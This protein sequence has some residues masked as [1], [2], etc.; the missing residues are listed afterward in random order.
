MHIVQ[1]HNTGQTHK[2]VADWHLM[3]LAILLAAVA[4]TRFHSYLLFHSLAELFLVVVFLTTF[5]IAW[6]VRA[7]LDT[8][9]LVAGISMGPVALLDMMHMLAFKGMGVFANDANLATQLWIAQ[10]SVNA[11]SLLAA[12]LL[13]RHHPRPVDVL[14]GITL[15]ALALGVSIFGGWFPDCFVEGQGLTGFKLAAEWAIMATFVVTLLKLRR[16]KGLFAPS[17]YQL[18][19]AAVLVSLVE[20]TTFTLY[21]DVYGVLNMTGHLLAVVAGYLLY[22][23]LVRYGLAHPQEVL[24]R[25]LNDANA[26]LTDVALRNNERAALALE[27]LDGA[28]WEWDMVQTD[29]TL[30]A[31][32]AGW[33]RQD[34]PPSLS[35]WCARVLPEDL[36]A[37]QAVLT[38]RPSGA[39]AS[40]EYR[41]RRNDG[42]IGWFTT[43]S[44]TFASGQGDRMVGV[45][46]DVTIRKQAEQER[47]RLADDVRK[48]A[49][50]LAHHLQEPARLQACYAQ[51][52]RRRLPP[53]CPPD[54]DEAIQ[55][56]ETGAEYLRHLLRDAHLYM[57]LDRLAPPDKPVDAGKALAE[58]WQHHADRARHMGATLEADTLPSVALAQPRLAELFSILL[59]NALEY[60]HPDRKPVVRVTCTVEQ[61][62]VVLHVA[63][64]GIG[65][66]PRY[67]QQIFRPFERLHTQTQHPGTGIGLALA[68]KIVETAGGRIWVSSD[69]DAGTTFH[70]A[71]PQGNP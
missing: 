47:E 26:R 45:D 22:A 25:Q 68:R 37:L 29:R 17:L 13:A 71:L 65:I 1:L 21:R 69:T 56:I 11:A 53:P 49:E 32:H 59:A 15:V 54:L 61:R 2:P 19:V 41:L 8:F 38:A 16:I 40:A 20:E 35:Q 6:N 7:Q 27:T 50:I 5:A 4:V 70:I 66:A 52:L 67:H 36:P 44:R 31:R 24:Y 46:R 55:V 23:G 33:L 34:H 18:L 42:S 51:L 3:V 64:N 43:S 28:P 60:R 30:T 14:G 58:A 48:F 63:D 57:V 9:L 62:E 12:A 10:R 39:A